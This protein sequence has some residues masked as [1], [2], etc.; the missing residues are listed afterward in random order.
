M[1]LSAGGDD[2]AARAILSD[3]GIGTIWVTNRQAVG[4]VKWLAGGM[5][6][7]LGYTYDTAI[8]NPIDWC[9]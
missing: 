6:G 8:M 2:G 4:K 9:V 7:E 1:V 3:Y 5:V